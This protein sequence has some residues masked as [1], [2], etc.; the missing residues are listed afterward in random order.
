MR[1]AFLALLF[2]T[3]CAVPQKQGPCTLIPNSY[4]HVEACDSGAWG[5]IFS[6]TGQSVFL[7]PQSS[8]KPEKK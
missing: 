1:Y 5:G 8:P 6:D 4:H 7:K 3:G 2:I